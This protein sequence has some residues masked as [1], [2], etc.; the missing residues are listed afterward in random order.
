MSVEREQYAYAMASNTNFE[1]QQKASN[2]GHIRLATSIAQLIVL[3]TRLVPSQCARCAYARRDT[4]MSIRLVRRVRPVRQVRPSIRILL[5]VLLQNDLVTPML[6]DDDDDN[7]GDD[8]HD[9]NL[10][11]HGPHLCV[12]PTLLPSR[13]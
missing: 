8:V 9:D 12:S 6:G 13:R 4:Y 5:V 10:C 1:D 11:R 2:W 3:G 7:V